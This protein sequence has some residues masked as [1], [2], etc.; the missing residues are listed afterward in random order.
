M[1]IETGWPPIDRVRGAGLDTDG[2]ELPLPGRV[3]I[4]LVDDHETVRQGLRLL[5]ERE[6]DF[7][8]V[9][10]V[11]DG[12]EAINR[13]VLED[14]DVVVM[15]VS[16]PG[17]S[18]ITATRRLKERRPNLA[19]V[20]LTRHA[21]QTFLAE[22]LSAGASGYVLKQSSQLELFRAIRAAVDGQQYIDSAL[23]H[24]LA[25]P[26]GSRQRNGGG[27]RAQALTSREGAVLRLVSLGYSNK[28]IAAR[29]EVSVKTVEV[30]K[31][32]SMRKLRLD[33]R[34][35]LLKYAMCQG[36]LADP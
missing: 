26:F 28:E 32:N 3:R 33:G 20:S 4:L 19:I 9:E 27:D 15:D 25:A 23:M 21:D 7:Q 12:A 29:L 10:E 22:L 35:E 2:R 34:I 30:H 14:L 24:H 5:I 1:A 16:M 13:P 36:W 18:G 17:T 6:P 11:S 31:T 8:V